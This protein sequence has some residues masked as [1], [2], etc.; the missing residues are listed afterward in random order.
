MGFGFQ[1]SY[2][3]FSFGLQRVEAQDLTELVALVQNLEL[4]NKGGGTVSFEA[5]ISEKKINCKCIILSTGA[6]S[7]DC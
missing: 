6:K 2:G 1:R 5:F 7:I 4:V 3:L